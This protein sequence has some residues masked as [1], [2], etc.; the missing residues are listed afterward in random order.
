VHLTDLS[1]WENALVAV[2]VGAIRISFRS[3]K[4]MATKNKHIFLL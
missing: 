2:V 4:L 3:D 1:K